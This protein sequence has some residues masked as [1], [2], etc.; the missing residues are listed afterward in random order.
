MELQDGANKLCL[1]INLVLHLNCF[2]IYS[3]LYLYLQRTWRHPC[4][5]EGRSNWWRKEASWCWCTSQHK[6]FVFVKHPC[7]CFLWCKMTHLD[8][9]WFQIVKRE[10][11]CT[12]LWTVAILMLSRFLSI[13]MQTSML[14]YLILFARF[15]HFTLKFLGQQVGW[16]CSWPK[17]VGD[18]ES[19]TN[20]FTGF[21]LQTAPN[22]Q[23]AGYIHC[24]PRTL[25]AS[26]G[27][28]RLVYW[29]TS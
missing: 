19:L 26:Y 11:H 25:S 7:L 3:E 21:V 13:Q 10:P 4:F 8:I 15:T 22:G 1:F 5:S 16:V 12:G 9:F 18:K 23:N 20:Y 27:L 14:R 29:H 24:N 28:A 2:C 17:E 6:R